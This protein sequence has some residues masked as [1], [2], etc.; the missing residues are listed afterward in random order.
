MNLHSIVSPYIAAVNPLVEIGI[1]SAVNEVTAPDGTRTPV[2]ATPGSLSG[3]IAG[4]VLTVASLSLGFLLPWQTVAGSGVAERTMIS[5]QLTGK[6]G[7]AGTYEVTRS[8]E[9]AG[10]IAMT[11]SVRI[12]AQVQPLTNR[13]LQQLEGLNLGGE[14]RAVY[15][16]GEIDGVVRVRLRGGDLIDLPDG[17]VWLVNQTVEDFNATAGWTKF[18]IT[19]QDGA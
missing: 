8:Q 14:K 1:R 13:D 16:T 9:V 12:F 2:Y 19:L 11:T 5:R 3:S 17:S 6:R 18:C 7:G 10:P 15:V 4:T